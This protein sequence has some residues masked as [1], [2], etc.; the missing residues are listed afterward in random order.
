MWAAMSD[1]ELLR[2]TDLA[3]FGRWVGQTSALK[4]GGQSPTHDIG[5]IEVDEVLKGPQGLTLALV[6][7]PA[8]Q[9]PRSS[10]DILFRRGA[11]GLWLLRK[12]SGPES[13]LYLADHPQRFVAESGNAQRIAA[14]RKLLA[15][16]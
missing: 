10:T 9:G 5:A 1:E 4:V 7:A 6:A 13:G 15:K 2:V 14:L 11:R 3:V 8:M 12:R 16:P